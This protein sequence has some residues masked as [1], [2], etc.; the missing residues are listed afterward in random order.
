MIEFVMEPTANS[1]LS[2]QILMSNVTDGMRVVVPD[3]Q[4]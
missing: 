3:N 1:R 4:H 2:C